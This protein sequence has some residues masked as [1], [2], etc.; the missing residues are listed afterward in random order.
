MAKSIKKNAVAKLALNILN[1]VIPL[2]TGPYLARTLDKYLY[3]EFNIAFSIVTWF[4]SFAAFGIYNYGIRIISQIKHDKKKTEVMFTSLFVMGMI[5]T[6]TVSIIYFIYIFLLPEKTNSWLYIVLSVQ[7][8]ANIFMVE[9]MNE[10]FESYG[11]IFFKTMIVRLI[12]VA[13]ILIFIKRPEDTLKY[14]MISS[15]V[16]LLNNLIS[17]IYIK[18]KINFC[19][20]TKKQLKSLVKPLF[21]MLL[22]ANASM[23]YTYLDKL[24]L[25][26]FSD[27]VYVTYYTFS[28]A[29]TSLIGGVINAVII[30]TIPRLSLYISEKRQDEY[31][32]LLYSSSRIFFMVGIPMCIGL[33]VLGTPIMLIYGGSDYIGAGTTMTLFAFRYILSL[34][35]LSLANQVIFI[36]GKE[37]LLTKMYLTGGAINLILNSLLVIS[38][39]LRPEIFVIT[40]FISEI[41]LISM[42]ISCIKKIDPEI[43]VLNKYVLRY[44][45]I[46]SMF[47]PI[48]FLMKKVMNIQYILNLK[49]LVDVGL[50][51]IVCSIF[52][53]IALLIFKDKALL[54]LLD[55]V[56]Q[57]LK[58]KRRIDK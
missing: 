46:S 42:M 49:F 17:Y 55:I 43:K 1:V 40:T 5:S 9:W 47:Y 7:I 24:F 45:V 58:F 8:I 35:D 27:G 11:F 30:V 38:G 13:S 21:V 25:S 37:N 28:Q 19:K 23:F 33:S 26:I 50:I 6:V 14:A 48:G 4:S 2:I 34:C 10:A 36:Y 18:K 22:V 51:I 32:N 44:F 3:G 57:K 54:Q 39:I 31:K 53:F 16:L 52:Y 20:V 56:F 15:C 41:I 29:I 12:N